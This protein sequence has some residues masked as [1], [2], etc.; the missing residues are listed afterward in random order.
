[1][2]IGALD[3][4]RVELLD[5]QIV[6][7]SPR[8]CEH[9]NAIEYLNR[10]ACG[11]P[12][13]YSVRVQSGL[14]IGEGWEPE[15]DLAI[16]SKR[17]ARPYHPQSAELAIEV[18]HTSLKRDRLVK[19]AMFARAGVPEYWI[20][21]IPDRVVEVHR[22]GDG[23]DYAERFTIGDGHLLSS[24]LPELELDLQ[25]LWSAAFGTP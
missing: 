1:M 16:I 3:D 22:A 13:E 20:V 25:A 14:T 23:E 17:I 21:A 19:R 10:L 5:G 15:P 12:L 8:T 24:A 2:E 9:D 4:E 11:L 6:A 18:A 7:M